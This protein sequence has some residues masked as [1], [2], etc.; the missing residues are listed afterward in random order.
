[1]EQPGREGG[2]QTL[3]PSVQDCR[4]VGRVG[5]LLET[6]VGDKVAPVHANRIRR[7]PDG[8]IESGDPKDGVFPDSLRMLQKIRGMNS[9]P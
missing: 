3:G 5:Y 1:M 8:L 4:E 7:I 6:E 2:S 9:S